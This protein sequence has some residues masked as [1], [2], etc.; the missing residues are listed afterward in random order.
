MGEGGGMVPQRARE[1]AR[2]KIHQAAVDSPR[3]MPVQ[4]FGQFLVSSGEISEAA[5]LEALDLQSE[6]NRKLGE[7]ASWSGYPATSAARRVFSSSATSARMVASSVRR[8]NQPAAPIAA[9]KTTGIS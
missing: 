4:F 5:L 6:R 1:G 7:W 8:L 9:A 2:V 3:G